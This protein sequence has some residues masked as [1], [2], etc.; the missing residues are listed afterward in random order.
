[1]RGDQPCQDMNLTLAMILRTHTWNESGRVPH[2]HARSFVLPVET[3]LPVF[4]F[5]RTVRT[6]RRCSPW[7]LVHTRLFVSASRGDRSRK[8][9]TTAR[10]STSWPS[11]QRAHDESMDSAANMMSGGMMFASSLRCA[12]DVP[13]QD[14]QLTAFEACVA[15]RLSFFIFA[16]QTRHA[17]L[18]ASFLVLAG[19]A[20][21]TTDSSR[22]GSSL[23]SSSGG[24]FEG[25]A[26]GEVAALPAGA[27]LDLSPTC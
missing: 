10:G 18:S 15:A 27:S 21:L 6:A 2:G 20:G 22:S 14:A 7:Q 9:L 13:W 1:M 23:S 8:R 3:S 12:V 5:Q 25:T 17:L 11:W 19:A 26:R 24:G 4:R 16:W